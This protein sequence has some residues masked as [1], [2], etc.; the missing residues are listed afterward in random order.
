MSQS[1]LIKEDLQKLSVKQLEKFATGVEGADLELVN[2]VITEKR[3]RLEQVT[4]DP[5]VAKEIAE[6]VEAKA[7][8]EAVVNA[9]AEAKAKLEAEKAEAKAA[10]EAL[11]AE[12]AAETKKLKEEAVNIKLAKIAE[13]ELSKKTIEE[14]K[15]AAVQAKEDKKVARLE[16]RKASL[17]EVESNKEKRAIESAERAAISAEKL[18]GMEFN[19]KPSKTTAVRKCLMQGMSNAQICV[20]TGFTNK[21]VCDTVWRIEQMIAQNE[22]IEKRRAEIAAS[23]A[24]LEATKVVE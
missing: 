18:K 2:E 22:Y 5:N 24:E 9:K 13:R 23:K 15:L 10:K 21:F 17:T 4:A 8:R 1:T 6:S 11:N 19:D 20:E 14:Q 7:A 12:K 3:S 16:A